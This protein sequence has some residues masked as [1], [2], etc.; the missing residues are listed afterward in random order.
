MFKNK[1]LYNKLNWLNKVFY[2][3]QKRVNRLLIDY[4]INNPELKIKSFTEDINNIKEKLRLIDQRLSLIEDSQNTSIDTNEENNDFLKYRS[5]TK[6][7]KGNLEGFFSSMINYNT[8]KLKYG[9]IEINP[10]RKKELIDRI[11]K[12]FELMKKKIPNDLDFYLGFDKKLNG[13]FYIGEIEGMI[14]MVDNNE[15]YHLYYRFDDESIYEDYYSSD[16]EDIL[17]FICWLFSLKIAEILSSRKE[18]INY[19][20]PS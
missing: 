9:H 7:H 16:S 10:F 13:F 1:D 3:N 15:D 5:L 17:Q 6:K 8:H 14:E 19:Q 11:K 4:S 2:E 20:L 12:G 18:L